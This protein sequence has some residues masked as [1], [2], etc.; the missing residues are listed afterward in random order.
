MEA[1][2]ILLRVLYVMFVENPAPDE[3]AALPMMAY[4]SWVELSG[5]ADYWVPVYDKLS[6]HLKNSY[7]GKLL[8]EHLVLAQG[9]T[10]SEFTLP[11][12]DG[13]TCSLRDILPKGKLT[14]VQFWASNSYN[15]GHFQEELL[16]LY[17]KYNEKGL[18]VIGVSAD[19]SVNKWKGGSLALI[20]HGTKCLT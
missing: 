4:C 17:K 13:K 8:K 7:Y 15:V 20:C 16:A 10:F 2:D 19:T 5:K 11:T 14:L 9:Q 1:K 3:I 18:N 12:P 6:D